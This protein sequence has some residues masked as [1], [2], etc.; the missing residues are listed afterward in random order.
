MTEPGHRYGTTTTP[1]TPSPIPGNANDFIEQQLDARITDIE[2]A[3]GSDAVSFNGPILF[4]VDDL[5]RNVIEKKCRQKQDI[6]QKD[7]RLVV[8][9]TTYGG[10]IE[11]V[12]RIVDTFRA[13]Y[14]VVEFVVPNYAYSAGTVLVM[15]GDAIHMD[16]YGRLGPI[17]PQ[18][19][20]QQAGRMVPALGYLEQ[21]S[22]LIKKAQDGDITAAE[23]QLLING[24]DQAEL[25]QYEHQRELSIALL[26]EWLTKY[27][28]KSWQVT[29]TRKKKVT[30]QMKKSRAAQI[31]KKLND[32][33]KWHSH[34]YGISKDVL[35]RDLNLIIDDF[36][37]NSVRCGK[38]RAYYD[39]LSDYMV[40]RGAKGVIHIAG[41]YRPFT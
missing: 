12:Q 17:D 29:R 14:P 18:I 31:A 30:V 8:I 19:E 11:V 6:P 26:K 25:Y 41:E 28:F 35:E 10:Y 15:S 37:E 9:L 1:S 32:T 7:R 16:Y 5:L 21:Y 33:E 27:K 38:I 20:T 3:F 34:G 39:L 24:F 13:H 4:G 22:R 36:G 23:V 40:K 2:T